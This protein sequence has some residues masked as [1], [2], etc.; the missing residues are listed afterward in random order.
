MNIGLISDIHA[1]LAALKTA[2]ALLRR[3]GTDVIVCAG[4]LIDKGPAGNEVIAY[5]RDEGIPCVR[6][7]HDQ[8]API[9][10]K[11]YRENPSSAYTQNL[12]LT[13]DSL[14]YLQALPPALSIMW[15]DIKLLVAH[16][17]PWNNEIYVFPGARRSLF[18]RVAEDVVNSGAQA[19]VLGH[20]HQPMMGQVNGIWLFNPGSVC[21]SFCTGSHTCAIL[22]LPEMAFQA[23]DIQTELPV[24]TSRPA[25]QLY[26]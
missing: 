21:G 9:Y 1:D 14:S 4:D 10:Q 24:R 23:F 15:G 20:T 16:G 13:E 11:W 17:T 26:D 6:G 12:L 8:R 18:T 25:Y 5:M 7:N 2:I 19:V 22:R 3:K